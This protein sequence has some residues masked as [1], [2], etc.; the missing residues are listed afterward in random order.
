MYVDE[1]EDDGDLDLGQNFNDFGGGAE[2][3]DDSD[4]KEDLSTNIGGN[5]E[6]PSK[7]STNAP[8]GSGK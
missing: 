8:V 7:L 4:D 1:D 2:D 6:N 3:D 5:N